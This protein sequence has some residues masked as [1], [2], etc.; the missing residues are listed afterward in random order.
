MK[1][2]GRGEVGVQSHS[3]V[4]GGEEG[5]GEGG[6][7]GGGGDWWRQPLSLHLLFLFFFIFLNRTPEKQVGIFLFQSKDLAEK[8]VNLDNKIVQQK[9]GKNESKIDCDKRAY[10]C[11]NLS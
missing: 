9:C 10:I 4:C 7:G 8:C 11:L 3:F 1:R 2:G 5:G 6:G